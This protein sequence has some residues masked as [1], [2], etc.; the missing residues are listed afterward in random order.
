MTDEHTEHQRIKVVDRRRF[1]QNGEPR[2]EATATEE[3][4]SADVHVPESMPADVESQPVSEFTDATADVGQQ[5]ASTVRFEHL[6]DLLAQ[7]AVLMLRGSNEV[8]PNRDQARSFID[9]LAVLEAKTQGNLSSNEREMLS[10]M[11]Y[12]LRT[13]YVQGRP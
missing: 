10:N 4:G 3:A 13:L 5:W 8:A 12:Q 7:Q 11:L 1:N 9:L 2:Y 6:V